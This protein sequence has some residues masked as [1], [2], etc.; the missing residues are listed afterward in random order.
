[1]ENKRV[2]IGSIVFV[3]VLVLGVF[4]AQNFVKA[5][6]PSP[7]TVITGTIV[8]RDSDTPKPLTTA[9]SFPGSSCNVKATNCGGRF[10]LWNAGTGTKYDSVNFLDTGTVFP[11]NFLFRQGYYC[12]VIVPEDC[13]YEV[14][15]QTTFD[16]R[17]AQTENEV[18][19]QMDQEFV[20][21][22]R[23]MFSVPLPQ[24][25]VSHRLLASNEPF[26][27]SNKYEFTITWRANSPRTYPE[28]GSGATNVCASPP[29]NYM[30]TETE[31]AYVV[32]DLTTAM[33]LGGY[34]PQNVNTVSTVCDQ[35]NE[36]VP[37]GT[38]FLN[39]DNSYH[40]SVA[41]SCT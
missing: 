11:K 26:T 15:I 8:L 37:S 27:R 39:T 1:M 12:N 33:Y 36:T 17:A 6:N 16:V 3:V 20:Q 30:V 21:V 22:Y 7:Q 18:L 4:V 28:C 23:A 19:V 32:Y 14:G 40:A 5:Q 35:I 24:F 34:D 41:Y 29:P 2:L 38:Y 13:P 31:I 10:W 25:I 9:V